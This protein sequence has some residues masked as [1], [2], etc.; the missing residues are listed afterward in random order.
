MSR[1]HNSS[2]EIGAACIGFILVIVVYLALFGDDPRTPPSRS[3]MESK[4]Q[5]RE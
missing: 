4:V 3:V 5:S 1:R 2:G